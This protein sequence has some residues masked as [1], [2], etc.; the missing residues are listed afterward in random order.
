MWPLCKLSVWELAARSGGLECGPQLDLVVGLGG[1]VTDDVQDIR[2][3]HRIGI[4][5]A[6]FG[7]G[8]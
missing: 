7:A 6:E 1:I 2:V 8:E 5:E 3:R 4:L